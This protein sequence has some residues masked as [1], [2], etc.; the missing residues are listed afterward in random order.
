VSIVGVFVDAGVD[1]IITAMDKTGIN[2]AQ[3]CGQLGLGDWSRLPRALGI[4]RAVP[5]AGGVGAD[6]TLKLP[7]VS[8][9]LVDNGIPG[10]HGGTGGTFDWKLAE[11]VRSWGRIWLAGGLNPQNVGDAIAEVHPH[12]VDVSSALETAPGIKSAE[13]IRSFIDA[14]QHA[15]H[16]IAKAGHHAH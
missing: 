8:D 4:L 16:A 1:E 14:V 7:G 12:A 5:F 2:V 6:P 15:D 10:S 3:L 11:S 9:Y 13:L